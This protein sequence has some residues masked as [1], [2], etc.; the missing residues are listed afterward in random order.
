MT[1]LSYF[2]LDGNYGSAVGLVVVD[3]TRFTSTMWDTLDECTD[4][5]RGFVAL[6]F[7]QELEG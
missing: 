6:R 3:T 4:G 2:G 1:E 5:E 7:A